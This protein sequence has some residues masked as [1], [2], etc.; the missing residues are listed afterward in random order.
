MRAEI[1]E[2]VR[3]GAEKRRKAGEMEAEVKEKEMGAEVEGSGRRRWGQR[4][5][6]RGR[7]GQES[8][9]CHVCSEG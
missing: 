6:D 9:F 2:K 7:R 8:I 3:L 1:E 4:P 5:R